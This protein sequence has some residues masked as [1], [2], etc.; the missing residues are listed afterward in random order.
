MEIGRKGITGLTALFFMMLSLPLSSASSYDVIV[1]RGDVPTDYTIASIY[2]STQKI[3]LVLVDPD[4]IESPIMQELSGYNNKG[5]SNLLIIGGQNAISASVEDKLSGMGFSVNRLWDW[6]R[7]GTA[8]RVAID[9]W[10]KSEDVIITN[11]EDYTGFLISQF[12][13]LERGAPILLA[14]NDTLPGETEDAVKKLGST[15]AILV[16][17]GRDLPPVLREMGLS[18]E[19]IAV[20]YTHLRAHET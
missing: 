16:N 1:V 6:N 11:G 3:P 7:Y 13:A 20:S 2:A 18:I 19:T 9:L 8:A 15:S 10:G 5:Y 4:N 14:M 12:I 17:C